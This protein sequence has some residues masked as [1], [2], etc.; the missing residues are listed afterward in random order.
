MHSTLKIEYNLSYH[1]Q[2]ELIEIF[3]GL[4]GDAL[5]IGSAEFVEDFKQKSGIKA[6]FKTSE[7]RNERFHLKE[8]VSSYSGENQEEIAFLREKK[9]IFLEGQ[10]G[11]DNGFHRSGP[12]MHP[13]MARQL[14]QALKVTEAQKVKDFSSFS[15]L[16]KI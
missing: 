5:A 3:N 7:Q 1:L 11:N 15:S 14:F 10:L 13:R 4:T 8:P 6:K 9:C 12:R 16:S 2:N